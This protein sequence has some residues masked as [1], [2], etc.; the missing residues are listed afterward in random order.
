MQITHSD[1][2]SYRLMDESDGQRLFELDQ[3]PEVMRF[4]NGGTQTSLQDIQAVYIPRMQSYRNSQQGWGLWQ[5]TERSTN[6]YLGWILIRPIKFFSEH[7]EYNNLEIGWR[8]FKKTWGKGYATEA[9]SHL[10]K[11]LEQASITGIIQPIDKISAY[12]MPGNAASI[13]VMKKLGMN[14]IETMLYKDPLGEETVVYY[15]KQ[16]TQEGS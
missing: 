16:L 14:Y 4:I 5:V 2:L 3:D 8:F 6:E 15:Q 9:A 13:A 7:P 10:I 11:C 1:R 12:A